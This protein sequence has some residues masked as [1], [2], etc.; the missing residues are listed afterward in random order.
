LI[1]PEEAARSRDP[2]S[3]REMF[4]RISPRY[5]LA[6]HVLSAG[7]DFFWRKHAAEIVAQW[8]PRCVLDLATGSGDL[9]LA[10][11]RR[12]P[13]SEITAADFSEEMLALARRKGVRKTVVAD[14]LRLPFAEQSFDAVTV[15]FGLR[16]MQDW[17][18]ALRQIRRVLTRSGHLLMLEF[19]LPP[20]SILRGAYRFYLHRILPR[21]CTVLTGDRSSY[22]YLGASIEN[23]PRGN[24]M[25][26]LINAN[27]FQNA[28]A[29]PVTGGI[30]TIYT[31][32][33]R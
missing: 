19:S 21:L 13:H 17:S 6:N 15:A 22:E 8:N 25:C 16:N 23:F 5:D 14:A 7:C 9:A 24:V 2:E 28:T 27:G 10:L 12:L 1:S 3:V 26:D 33:S 29:E 30:V 4:S 18:V 20:R 31:A 11:Q 32:G